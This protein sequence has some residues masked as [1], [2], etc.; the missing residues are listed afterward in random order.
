MASFDD[1]NDGDLAGALGYPQI[2]LAQVSE[3][4]PEDNDYPPGYDGYPEPNYPQFP[5]YPYNPEYPEPCFL[6]GT[7]IATPAGECPVEALKIRDEVLTTQGE[8]KAVKWI[9]HR[10]V[11]T[12]FADRLS[13]FPVLVQAGAL[14]EGVPARDLYLSPDH[15]LLVEGILV[16]AVALVNGLTIRQL[17][18]MPQERFTYWH[19]ELEDHDLIL[20][21]GTPAETF[22]DNLSR[23]SFD[24]WAEYEDCYGDEN[25][26]AELPLPRVTVRGQLSRAI[27]ARL[28]ERAV[29]MAKIPTKVA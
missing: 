8:P 27:G 13:S 2:L 25:S 14:A 26:I 10:T 19:V 21:E 22:V 20:A 24:N 4:Y 28:R 7:A 15:A 5:Y 9:G 17:D 6:T 11:S 23:R 3:E 18:Q 1:G 29:A 12:R 16:H